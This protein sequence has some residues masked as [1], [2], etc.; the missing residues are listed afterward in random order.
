MYTT[1]SSPKILNASAYA[2][3]RR[4]A[5]STTILL[6]G[7]LISAI[8]VSLTTSVL[9]SFRA[10][11]IIMGCALAFSMAMEARSGLRQM[12][13]VDVF[14]LAVLYLL[15]FLEFLFPQPGIEWR[16]TLEAAQMATYAVLLGF[17]GIAFGRHAYPL[18]PMVSFGG[19]QVMPNA[20]FWM[21]LGSFFFGYLY[22]FLSV[23]FDIGEAIYQMSRPR[24]SQPW[25]RGRFGSL[26]TLLNELGLLK[27]LLPPLIAS[28]FAQSQQYSLLQ[29]LIVIP[30][31]ALVMFE[32][33]AEGTRNVFLAHIAT[34]SATYAL[35]HPR[36]NLMRAFAFF[37]PMM[38]LVVVSV[39]FMA[40]FRTVGLQNFDFAEQ[41]E[42]YVFVDLNIVNIAELT[43]VFPEKYEYL[44][45]EIPIV[46]AVRPI[47]RALWPGK[48]EGL[49]ISIEDALGARGLTLSTTFIGEF[50]MAGGILAIGFGGLLLGF[51]AS[52]WNRVGA[53]ATTNLG[54]VL[55]ASGF[56]TAGI[57][58]RSFLSVAPTILPIIAL[59]AYIK[60]T[61]NKV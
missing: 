51:L 4:M 26:S 21:I 16:L 14:M 52:F 55:Y 31:L 36:F 60:I 34:F 5:T 3:R 41:E 6:G 61:R 32:A 27:Y 47:P 15:T 44:G 57:C 49:S 17:A 50:W 8:F 58:M 1:A 53:N 13:R 25:V 42:I 2:S 20:T 45:A 54:F 56:F 43:E 7:V 33:F 40:T 39:L 11:A 23:G 29:K 35:T 24:F 10:A 28:V 9:E 18:K 59:F 38:A 48:P 37:A 22:I 12:I 30:I 19:L 46:A